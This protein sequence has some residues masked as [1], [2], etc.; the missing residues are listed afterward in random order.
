M[1]V[2]IPAPDYEKLETIRHWTWMI[3]RAQ[4]LL[5]DFWI[6][7]SRKGETASP[8]A[9]QF[10]NLITAV[11][12][13][14][15]DTSFPPAM[16]HSL[17]N[18]GI[19]SL[20]FWQEWLDAA[21]QHPPAPPLDALFGALHRMHRIKQDFFLAVLDHI[22]ASDGEEKALM[23][24]NGRRYLD[25]ANPMHHLLTNP[26]ALR[27]IRESRGENLLCALSLL[28]DDLGAGR[29][30]LTPDSLLGIGQHLICHLNGAET[31]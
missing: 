16:L 1:T 14:M 2:E 7:E 26:D 12:K 8:A 18:T 28:L 21:A 13:A 27:A 15:A 9:R 3:G 11:S 22:E 24:A 4:Q 20:V 17:A 23:R 5:L 25:A 31:N 29:I 30:E 10:I 19:Q 6:R